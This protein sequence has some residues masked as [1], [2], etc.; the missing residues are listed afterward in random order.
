MTSRGRQRSSERQRSIMARTRRPRRIASSRSPGHEQ[1]RR[2]GASADRGSRAAVPGRGSVCW[3]RGFRRRPSAHSAEA[4]RKI[5][6]RRVRIELDAHGRAALTG[7]SQLVL[8]REEEAEVGLEDRYAA[9]SSASAAV[10][11][12]P[13]RAPVAFEVER[14]ESRS[15]NALRAAAGS[16]ARARVDRVERA[17]LRVFGRCPAVDAQ[18][19]VAV[20]EPCVRQ[21]IRG[22]RARLPPRS[23]GWPSRRRRVSADSRNSGPSDTARRPAGSRWTPHD[24]SRSPSR[25]GRERADDRLDDV[26]LDVEDIGHLAV[27]ALGPDVITVLGVRQL[28]VDAKRGRRRGGRC[29]R[30]SAPTPSSR[31]IWRT[32]VSVP[33]NGRMMSARPPA[34]PPALSAR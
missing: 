29:L 10:E 13:R 33:G 16:S 3:T 26:V 21:R 28:C 15:R 20:G 4:A 12:P 8:G 5:D 27:V 34:A 24:R 11:V 6:D 17:R 25:A 32:S 19:R 7:L 22:D 31:P 9:G 18:D 30:A 14:V 1:A 23:G 2:F